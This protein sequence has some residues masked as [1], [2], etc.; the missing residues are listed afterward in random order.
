MQYP[1]TLSKTQH[2]QIQS[3]YFPNLKAQ[4]KTKDD[5][6]DKYI[7]AVFGEILKA[8]ENNVAI[9]EGIAGNVK[10]KNSFTLPMNMALKIKLHNL[11]LKQNVTKPELA[12]L[13]S[14]THDDVPDHNWS[15]ENLKTIKPSNPPKYKNSERLFKID[16]ESTLREIEQAYRVL[17]FNVDVIPYPKRANNAD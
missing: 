9:S 11:R 17:G 2:F 3:P 7:S 4:G 12:R 1:Y 15:L 8:M 13:L 5:A 14:I 16:H 10:K 6:L